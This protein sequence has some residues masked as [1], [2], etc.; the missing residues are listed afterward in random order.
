MHLHWLGHGIISYLQFLGPGKKHALM[1]NTLIQVS[2]VRLEEVLG[3]S[4]PSQSSPR[5]PGHLEHVQ[6]KHDRLA[7]DWWLSLR[8]FWFVVF[9]RGLH[10]MLNILWSLVDQPSSCKTTPSYKGL[11][12][13]YFLF[14]FLNELLTSSRAIPRSYTKLGRR[15]ETFQRELK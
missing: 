10:G 13:R 3:I 1:R 15:V 8:C 7:A 12:I 14:H 11:N 5:I 4:S 9:L 6:H 2:T